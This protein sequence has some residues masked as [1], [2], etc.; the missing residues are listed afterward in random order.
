MASWRP[1]KKVLV[2]SSI[3]ANIL[4]NVWQKLC[5]VSFVRKN[6]QIYVCEKG[7]FMLM[8]YLSGLNIILWLMDNLKLYCR[9]WSYVRIVWLCCK[10]HFQLWNT[11]CRTVKHSFWLPLHWRL[12][13]IVAV[14]FLTRAQ[15]SISTVGLN[16]P[17]H[18]AAT[19][20]RHRPCCMQNINH[21][22]QQTSPALYWT[23]DHSKVVHQRRRVWELFK[24]TFTWQDTH[25]WLGAICLLQLPLCS[26][27]SLE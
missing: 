16:G 2:A 15:I 25:F 20:M 3:H 8:L 21:L 14:P 5:S 6:Y 24:Q 4:I 19:I 7:F 13:N 9:A 17:L 1:T 11:N 10:M 22:V 27:L 18:N 26:S 12:L 23:S